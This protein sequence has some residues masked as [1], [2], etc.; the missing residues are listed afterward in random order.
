VRLN[1]TSLGQGFQTILNAGAPASGYTYNFLVSIGHNSG[2]G[3]FFG[4]GADVLVNLPLFYD[5]PPF[6]GLLDAQ[7]SAR[8]EFDP[9]SIPAG[10]DADFVFVLQQPG[11]AISAVS[12]VLAFDS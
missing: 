4:L 7:G 5:V 12:H 11:G 6:S 10:I 8:I 2:L 9:G 1:E 3:P